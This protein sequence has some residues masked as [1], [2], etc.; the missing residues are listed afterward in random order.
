MNSQ[1]HS[2]TYH[3]NKSIDRS[4]HSKS[5]EKHILKPTNIPNFNK[6]F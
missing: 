1:K 3:P 6:L 2:K 5:I 4:P